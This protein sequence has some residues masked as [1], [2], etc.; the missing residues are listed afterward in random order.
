MQV[1][2][3]F[4]ALFMHF[5]KSFTQKDVL[6]NVKAFKSLEFSFV[7]LYLLRSVIK[8]QHFFFSIVFKLFTFKILNSI[9]ELKKI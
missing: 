7:Q 5:K 2:F 8:M 1:H 6:K 3:Q 4:L 9:R